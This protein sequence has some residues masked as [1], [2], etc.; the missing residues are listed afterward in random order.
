MKKLVPLIPRPAAAA[1]LGIGVST[2]KKWAR[3]DPDF[4][5]T[6]ALSPT[7][8][9]Y[10]ADD[11]ARYQTILQKRATQQRP[12]PAIADRAREY[13]LMRSAGRKAAVAEREAVEARGKESKPAADV[14]ADIT[15]T[16]P[17]GK[18]QPKP[19]RATA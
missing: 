7:R 18:R 8:V 6:I 14:T 12:R 2:C 15:P 1:L 4:P 10:R 5:P 3:T 11:L 13:A 19:A 9:A 16:K 17:S